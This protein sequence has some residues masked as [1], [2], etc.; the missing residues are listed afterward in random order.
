[1]RYCEFDENGYIIG[2]GTGA[3][4]VEIDKARYDAVIAALAL[5]PAETDTVDYKLKTD[6]TWESY[7]V[8]PLEPTPQEIE[9]DYAEAGR[10][11]LGVV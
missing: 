7:Q 10:I 9:S 2:I 4:G 3:G 1:M 6:L 5:K 8:E 11:L